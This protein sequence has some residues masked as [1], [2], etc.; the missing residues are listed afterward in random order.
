MVTS[1]KVSTYLLQK[2]EQGMKRRILKIVMF[3]MCLVLCVAGT[4]VAAFAA[5]NWRCEFCS[6]RDNNAYEERCAGCG[7]SNDMRPTFKSVSDCFEAGEKITIKWNKVAGKECY[8]LAVRNLDTDERYDVKNLKKESYTYKDGLPAGD[9]TA[10]LCVT[11]EM[12]YQYWCYEEEK[13]YFTVEEDC[14]TCESC[15]YDENSEGEEHCEACGRSDWMRPSFSTADGKV[16]EAEDSICIKWNSQKNAKEYM[17]AVRNTDTNKRY[18]VSGIKKNKYTYDGGEL[19]AGNYVA[20][21]RVTDKRDNREYWCYEEQKI[22][23]RVN[24]P[25]VSK[26]EESDTWQDNLYEEESDVWQDI[27]QE[28]VKS[29]VSQNTFW[30]DT[31]SDVFVVTEDTSVKAEP[32]YG[33][34]WLKEK[35][36][37]KKENI[38]EVFSIP[39]SYTVTTTD[40][41][42]LSGYLTCNSK[43]TTV[44]VGVRNPQ[45]I[46]TNLPSQSGSRAF[47]LSRFTFDFSELGL[48]PGDYEITVWAKTE[49]MDEVTEP[50]V[51]IPITLNAFDYSELSCDA[52]VTD[53][54]KREYINNAMVNYIQSNVSLQNTLRGVNRSGKNVGQ[55]QILFFFEGG[56]DNALENPEMKS[57]RNNAILLLVKLSEEGKPQ[58]VYACDTC[59]TIP[60]VPTVYGAFD[61]EEEKI[62]TWFDKSKEYGPATIL[63]G[64]YSVSKKNHNGGHAALNINSVD[65]FAV[66]LSGD[67]K[68]V[69]GTAAGINI[70]RRKNDVPT[71]NPLKMNSL[72]CINVGNTLKIYNEYM[73]VLAG[74]I[75][76]AY[77]TFSESE[78]WEW[79]GSTVVD[80]QL[81]KDQMISLYGNEE[82]VE[83]I[84]QAS[85]GIVK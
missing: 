31:E 10:A 44:T 75:N 60:D 51:T 29:D 68:Y 67:G 48:E 76:G 50:I 62:N 17:L 79:M 61:P 22:S 53:L 24:A 2:G 78:E 35:L 46:P 13:I 18:D 57:S 63:D 20:S 81:F 14:W 19:P 40:R 80:R 56:S 8:L 25:V 49:L 66:Y 30:E 52:Y 4:A 23:F 38:I 27:F 11:D 5:S 59:T 74:K 6:Y 73:E 47:D 84:L 41:L 72:G 9:Y 37:G 70:H 15:G 64:I 85:D 26:T 12:G 21:L 33:L 3:L 54:Q 58:V 36:F 39:K 16:F 7:R 42:T 82:A 65:E 43:F 45:G 55:K 34:D 28:D 1:R 69:V 32:A 71:E 77:T 83:T